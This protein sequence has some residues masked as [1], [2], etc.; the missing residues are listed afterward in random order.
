M[1]AP[2]T[3]TPRGWHRALEHAHSRGII[4]RDLKPGNIWLTQDATAKL[5]DF[6]LAV[7]VDRSR[8]T[9]EGMMVGTVAY[10]AREQALGRFKGIFTSGRG[11]CSRT[12]WRTVDSPP[13]K[14]NSDTSRS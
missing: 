12:Y 14:P 11:R 9:M 7:S 2:S 4:H 13:R 8:L 1:P 6:G 3:A 5:G 10:M